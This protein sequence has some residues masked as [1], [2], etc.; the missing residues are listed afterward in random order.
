MVLQKNLRILV[1]DGS[2][3]LPI[4]D[5][6]IQVFKNEYQ[7]TSYVN[8]DS[9]GIGYDLLTELNA[10]MWRFWT[11]DY[12]PKTMSVPFDATERTVSLIPVG[13]L[14]QA[15]PVDFSVPI[16]PVS[17]TAWE[18]PEYSPITPSAPVLTVEPTGTYPT[19]E[20]GLLSD[21][22]DYL[23]GI[24]PYNGDLL[25]Y[26][27]DLKGDILKGIVG[28][29]PP[30]QAY[31]IG[32]SGFETGLESLDTVDYAALA[33]AVPDAPSLPDAKTI[34]IYAGLALGGLF[35]LKELIRR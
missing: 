5:R 17:G 30:V 8:L 11:H 6:L 1:K 14:E 24:N 32:V 7:E 31:N 4:G 27:G 19:S 15:A 16:D 26:L 22:T 25:A 13:A 18:L 3:G 2:T 12:E 23:S 29:L 35:V 28:L 34:L 20:T 21:I 9:Q 33:D 10:G